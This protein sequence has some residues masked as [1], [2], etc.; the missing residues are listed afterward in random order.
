MLLDEGLMAQALELLEQ[1]AVLKSLPQLAGRLRAE[2][3]MAALAPQEAM[4][5][6]IAVDDSLFPHWR[7]ASRA[8]LL[9]RV[10][11]EGGSAE[12]AAL[13]HSLWRE[14]PWHV[15]ACLT[16]AE[17]AQPLSPAAVD[18]MERVHVLLYSW[19]KAQEL[20]Q[21]LDSLAASILG[22]ARV[23]CL[24]NGSSDETLDMLE[25]VRSQWARRPELPELQVLRLP[26]NIGAP[27]ARQWLLHLP[28]VR[29]ADY[30]AF[31][32]D[33][34]F[35]PRDWLGQMLARAQ[36]TPHMSAVGCR[37][38]RH[39]PPHLLQAADFNI[40]H[41]DSC[42]SGF[43]DLQEKI[44]VSNNGLGRRDSGLFCYS[45]PCVSV[46]GCCHLLRRHSLERGGGF[47]IRFSPSQFDD[48]ERDLRAYASGENNVYHGSLVV[49]HVQ[50]S[51][52]Q[53]ASDRAR[54][55]HIHGNKIKLEHMF[56]KETVA[57]MAT[58][59]QRMLQSDFVSK[60]LFLDNSEKPIPA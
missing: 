48:L 14:L 53:Q 36:A 42:R 21:T 34:I 1:S 27:A 41:P 39:K 20:S 52:L 37:I 17:L 55:S 22:R 56:D 30:V 4:D 8:S 46:T 44:F 35:L 6:V 19:N 54:Q 43:V 28:Q 23:T 33:D 5:F 58:R 50:H 32:D 26:V 25:K 38:E 29:D 2:W 10:A 51:S 24:D 31:L 13:L 16:A 15:N 11:P 47:D 49:R 12:A 40:M 57:R 18:D 60:A 45:R 3:A 59:C 7:S 9:L